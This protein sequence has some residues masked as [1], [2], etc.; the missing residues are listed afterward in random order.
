MLQ[1]IDTLET[2]TRELAMHHFGESGMNKKFLARPFKTLE[3]AL[4]S[5][6]VWEDY[7]GAEYWENIITKNK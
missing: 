3:D 4:V 7:E 6:F 2:E 1:W 5:A